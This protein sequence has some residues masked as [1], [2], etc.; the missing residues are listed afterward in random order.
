TKTEDGYYSDI[1]RVEFTEL[2]NKYEEALK[3]KK[4]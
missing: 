2:K 4:K 3:E 1:S